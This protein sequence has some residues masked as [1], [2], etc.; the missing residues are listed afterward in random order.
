MSRRTQFGR[1]MIEML[2]VL[3][4]IGVLS[5]GGLAG[6][7]KAMRTNRVNNAIDY[8]NRAQ[9]EFRALKAAGLVTTMTVYRCRTLLDE[10]LPT[11]IDGCQFQDNAYDFDN[12]LVVHFAT[13]DFFLDVATKINAS[14]TPSIQNNIDNADWLSTHSLLSNRGSSSVYSVGGFWKAAFD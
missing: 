3:A 12:Q 10:A 4:I 14:G 7:S 6:Y 5:I 8:I 1:S 13:G 11:G 2:G 9:V